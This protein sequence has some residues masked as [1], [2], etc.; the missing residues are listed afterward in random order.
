M[1]TLSEIGERGKLSQPAPPSVSPASL[2]SR[3]LNNFFSFPVV[4]ACS[5]AYL[6]FLFSRR[7]LA[8]P[9]LW[10][11]LRNA[12]LLLTTGHFRVVDAYSYTASGAAVLP[13]EWLAEIPYYLAFKCAG[14]GLCLPSF[15]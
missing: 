3:V 5:L 2:L 9:D 1:R 14:L 12:Q 11:H 6:M 15:S 4:L 13:F 10:W 7:D 8:D